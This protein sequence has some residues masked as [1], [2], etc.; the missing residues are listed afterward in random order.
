[1]ENSSQE[2]GISI[3]WVHDQGLRRAVLLATE[4]GQ[5]RYHLT[6]KKIDNCSRSTRT[7]YTNAQTSTYLFPPLPFHIIRIPSSVV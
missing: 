5:C 1:M 7:T 2:E 3:A 4:N 6:R